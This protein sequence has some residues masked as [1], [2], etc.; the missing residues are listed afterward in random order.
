MIC[1]WIL[2]SC[3]VLKRH[4]QRE[5]RKSAIIGGVVAGVLMIPL[6]VCLICNL[7]TGNGLSWFFIVLASI[8]V[9]A[10][11]SVTPLVV[12]GREKKFLW[13]L[14][15]FTVTLLLLLMVIA[16]Y[17]RGN[18]FFIA[19]VPTILG[20]SVFFA[21]PVAYAVF[22]KGALAKAK[23]ILV[24]LWDTFWLYAVI[25]VCGLYV[26][27]PEYWRVALQI[28][29]FSAV[30]VWIVFLIARYVKF[31]KVGLPIMVKAGIITIVSGV[32][33][34]S[35]NDIINWIISGVYSSVYTSM[36][37]SHWS[38]ETING[39]VHAIILISTITVGL[40][41]LIAGLVYKRKEE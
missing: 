8:L 39:N 31:P 38:E 6:I 33:I 1:K 5:T 15:L 25:F 29:T 19:A 3:E 41:L 24:M 2:R 10:S 12:C 23:G 4:A 32:I 9:T 30:L 20:L 7:A 16:I 28:T 34:V 40:I 13:T 36:D 18:W 37:L 14:G 27:T 11:L 22:K 35:V 17:V 21:P 26:E